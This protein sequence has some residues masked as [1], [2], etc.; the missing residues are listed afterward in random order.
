MKFNVGKC[1]NNVELMQ[2]NDQ[3]V[4]K[5]RN[6]KKGQNSD[7]SQDSI[8]DDV[9]SNSSTGQNI[10]DSSQGDQTS[11]PDKDGNSSNSDDE[12]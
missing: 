11:G 4:S 3:N 5:G 7:V 1:D 9:L 2:R 8:P 10:Q 6:S 12:G